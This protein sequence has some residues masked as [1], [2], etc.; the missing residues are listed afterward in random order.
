MCRCFILIYLFKLKR[1]YISHQMSMIHMTS[2]ETHD[3][4][5]VTLKLFQ[6][7]FWNL[8]LWTLTDCLNYLL[9]IILTYLAA[10]RSGCCTF[11]ILKILLPCWVYT[12]FIWF[13]LAIH[14]VN[15]RLGIVIILW[16]AHWLLKLRCKFKR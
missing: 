4:A 14:L 11:Y 13:P 3:F 7:W 16:N 5:S 8:L 10:W 9:N 15:V 1:I 2:N 12:F 6:V